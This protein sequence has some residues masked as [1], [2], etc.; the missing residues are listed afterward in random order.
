MF[1]VTLGSDFLTPDVEYIGNTEEMTSDARRFLVS[2]LNPQVEQ[3]IGVRELYD[4]YMMAAGLA[5]RRVFHEVL[6]TEFSAFLIP[7]SGEYAVG[8][9]MIV[10]EYIVK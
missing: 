1:K 3:V 7:E 6:R 4:K 9:R 5:T 8:E 2:C 10:K